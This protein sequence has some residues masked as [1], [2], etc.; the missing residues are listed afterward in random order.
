MQGDS[1]KK[2]GTDVMSISDKI[3]KYSFIFM[4]RWHIPFLKNKYLCLQGKFTGKHL[5][6][7]EIYGKWRRK[8]HAG[9]DI[10][11]EIC[12]YEFYLEITDVRH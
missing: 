9:Y 12:G 11:L 7:F 4:P 10:N 1:I 8:D 6:K 2:K 3:R 5:F